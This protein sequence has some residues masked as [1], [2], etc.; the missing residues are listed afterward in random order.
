MSYSDKGDSIL[1]FDELNT[2]ASLALL[3]SRRGYHKDDWPEF[4]WRRRL[5]EPI[6]EAPLA[7]GYSLRS[8]GDGLELLERLLAMETV[9]VLSVGQALAKYV[10]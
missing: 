10:T 6:P 5:D 9:E 3:L 1:I 8:L 4:Q 2:A 7:A